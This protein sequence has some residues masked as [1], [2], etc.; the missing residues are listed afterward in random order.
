M[1]PCKLQ[2][3]ASCQPCAGTAVRVDGATYPPAVSM[4]RRL[5][6]EL[7]KELQQVVVGEEPAGQGTSA[8]A[9]AAANGEAASILV[10]GQPTAVPA[11]LS[12]E[13][14]AAA[15]VGTGAGVTRRRGWF[16]RGAGKGSGAKEGPVVKAVDE[17]EKTEEEAVKVR[18]AT[19]VL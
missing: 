9:S 4:C 16:S 3:L 8:A 15:A 10:A 12:T 17:E 6:K 5:S 19:R 11:A 13:A 18:A 14:A 2:T 1:T 7:S